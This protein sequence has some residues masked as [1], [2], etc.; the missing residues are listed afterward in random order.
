VKS[1]NYKHQVKA[2]QLQ[3]ALSTM[4]VV[5][6]FQSSHFTAKNFIDLRKE[7]RTAFSSV[8]LGHSPVSPSGVS[9]AKP[10]RAP[11]YFT[12]RNSVYKRLVA[13]EK[14]EAF[15]QLFSGPNFLFCLNWAKSDVASGRSGLL[16]LR[17]WFSACMDRPNPLICIS[18]E[19][20]AS[21]KYGPL[22]VVGCII[23]GRLFSASETEAILV[24]K[25]SEWADV[26]CF[27]AA[28][29]TVVSGA[30][31]GV[32]SANEKE[33]F[34]MGGQSLLPVLQ[35]LGASTSFV[36]ASFLH[37]LE[38]QAAAGGASKG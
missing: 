8:G 26:W 10:N 38:E 27:E 5:F 23:E 4:D 34:L 35:T 32:P 16:A 24:S 19:G 33:D 20:S 9:V 13:G 36:G 30:G 15:L 37:C 17:R 7:A 2:E 6:V 1:L 28:E 18:K 21:G 31:R 11:V 29:A 25:T 3:T 22:A 12:G 14:Y